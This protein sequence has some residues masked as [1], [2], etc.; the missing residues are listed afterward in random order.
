[1]KKLLLKIN[2]QSIGDTLSATPL[3]RYLSKS[4][5]SKL[6]IVTHLVDIFKNNPYIYKVIDINQYNE[7]DYNDYEKME[8][9]LPNPILRKHNHIDI[10]QFHSFSLGFMLPPEDLHTEFYPDSYIDM[11][12]PDNYVVIHPSKTWA[13]RT[14]EQSRWGELSEK[15]NDYG[16]PIVIVGKDS[17]EI[18]TYNTQK[19]VYDIKLKN[20]INLVNKLNIHQLYHVLNKSKV[21]IT[22]D[23]GILHL[24]GSTD[25]FIIQ[26]GSSISPRFRTPYRHGKQSYKYEYVL[27]NCK[28]F[29]G[30]NLKYHIRV[31]NTIHQLPPLPFCLENM[32]SIDITEPNPLVYKCHPDSE[33]VYQVF[34]KVYDNERNNN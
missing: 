34:K 31:H 19:P 20:G 7:S 15:I 4:Y 14:W 9:F 18:G 1:M 22:M 16:V 26:L 23:S 28:L 29:C 6:I 10:R 12:L 33:K 3:I 2:C 11:E 5:D 8:T 25:T 13:S 30:S 21:V 32:E 27:G 24:A 17:S